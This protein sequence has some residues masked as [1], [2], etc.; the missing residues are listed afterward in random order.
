MAHAH[1][2]QSKYIPAAGARWL[3]RFYDP[4]VALV[5]RE[6]EFRSEFI[7]R[8]RIEP[9]ARVRRDHLRALMARATAIRL[10]PLRAATAT[11]L[12]RRL[13]TPPIRFRG[14]CLTQAGLI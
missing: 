10:R 4:F 7:R 9:N 6:R 2:A 14:V 11:R 3:T 12:P 1:T 8:A 13:P 5:M